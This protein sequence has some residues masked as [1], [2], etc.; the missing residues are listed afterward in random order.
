MTR[1]VAFLIC[2]VVPGVA[3]AQE[4]FSHLKAKVGQHLLVTID[5]LTASGV[6]TELTPQR[7]VVGDREFEP[8]PGMKIER[9]GDSLWNGAAIGFGLGAFVLFPVLPE[10]GRAGP[11]RPVNGLVWAAI[12]ALIDHEHV[13]RTIILDRSS[14]ESGCNV[15]F[16]PDVS[17]HRKGAALVVRF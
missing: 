12:G 2:I 13:G 14:D 16:V 6:L 7:I 3:T 11:F 4:D 8:G 9:S 15:H 10:G 5:G 17:P 1:M